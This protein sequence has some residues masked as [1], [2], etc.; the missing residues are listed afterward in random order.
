M[1]FFRLELHSKFASIDI[2]PEDL[3][4]FRNYILNHR[5]SLHPSQPLGGGWATKNE[6]WTKKIEG[7]AK[8]YEGRA[9]NQTFAKDLF[10]V[11]PFTGPKLF[12]PK[13]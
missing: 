10:V 7:R 13:T 2:F 12:R 4:D 11:D 8:K 5:F 9:K 1:Q 3:T 6:G